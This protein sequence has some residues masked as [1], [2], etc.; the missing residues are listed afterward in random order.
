[1]SSFQALFAGAKKVGGGLGKVGTHH[2]KL[3][4]MGVLGVLLIVAGSIFPTSA[5]RDSDKPIP[6]PYSVTSSTPRSY[7]DI[8]EA[9]LGNLL[10][11]VKGAGAVAVNVTL[12]TGAMQEYAKNIVRESKTT[13]E[14]DTSGGTRSTIETKETESILV[15]KENGADRPVM[16]REHKP[17]IKGVLVIAEGA[18]DSQIKTQLTKAVE[19]S[20][21]IPSYKITVLPQRK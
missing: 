1:M 12:E 16:L 7:E 17:V 20:L 14:K 10:S 9:K 21:G 18:G 5:L 8:L 13:Q 19:T 11:Q 6:A 4:W 15:S 3:V 2:L